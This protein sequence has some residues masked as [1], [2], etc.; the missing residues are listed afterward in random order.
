MIEY[1]LN[2][3]TKRELEAL[4]EALGNSNTPAK[5]EEYVAKFYSRAEHSAR[6]IGRF[7]GVSDRL[8]YKSILLEIMMELKS[9][10][11]NACKKLDH[12]HIQWSDEHFQRLDASQLEVHLCTYHNAILLVESGIDKSTLKTVFKYSSSGIGMAATRIPLG[13]IPGLAIAAPAVT[14]ISIAYFGHQLMS[15]NYRKLLPAVLVLISIGRRINIREK[16]KYDNTL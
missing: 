2:M 8:S 15:P 5:P 11:L 12:H 3:A 13:F 14:A 1:R 9:D 4:S 6:T 10:Y 16:M 7:I